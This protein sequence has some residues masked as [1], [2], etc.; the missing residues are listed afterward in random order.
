M[1]HLTN[2]GTMKIAFTVGADTI[3]EDALEEERERKIIEGLT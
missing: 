3:V 2:F 1:M